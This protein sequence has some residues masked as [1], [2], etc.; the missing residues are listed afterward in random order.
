M[1]KLFLKLWVF[2]ILTS[3]TSFL[4]QRQVFNW[5]TQEAN[6]A[7]IL[8]RQKRTFVFVEETLRPYPKEEWPMRLEVVAQRLGAPARLI[9]IDNL[10]NTGELN[11][12]DIEKIR[13]NLIHIRQLAEDVGVV[14][15]RAIHDSDYVAAIEIPAPP[16]PKVFGIFKPLVFTWIVECS[17]YALAIMLWLRLFWRDLMRLTGAAEK[18]GADGFD[19]DVV[20]HLGNQDNNL[21]VKLRGGSALK[22]LG[23]A[24]NRMSGRI[25]ALMNSHKEL[26]TAVSHELKTPL[27]RLRF[28][29][30]LVPDADTPAE[31]A[32]L[33]KKMQHDVDEL[34]SL[35]QEMLVY[36]KLERDQPTIALAIQPVESWLSAAVEDEIEAANIDD[37]HIP[38]TIHAIQKDIACEPKFMA[39][40]VR[41]LVRNALRYATSRIEVNVNSDDKQYWIHVDD[42]GPGI[43]P[44]DREKLFVPFS[45]LTPSRTREAGKISGSGLGLAIVKRIAEWHGGDVLITT[46]PLGGAR[47]SIRWTVT[48]GVTAA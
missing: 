32:L 7:Y 47:I 44:N 6:A 33:L 19:R 2:I 37:I 31:R 24:I 11:A 9:T 5:T 15:Y 34:D 14:M 43:A 41:N 35:V 17:L 21:A 20:N 46:S 8:E 25:K 28:A 23:D 36:A 29:I 3:L 38:V 12:G 13:G 16:K 27:S 30:S 18:I 48:P 39:R 45:R 22:P 1:G 26:T 42:D 4:I 40:A 10:A